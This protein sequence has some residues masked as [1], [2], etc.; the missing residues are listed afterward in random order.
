[1]IFQRGKEPKC[2]T[3]CGMH[4]AVL[5]GCPAMPAIVEGQHQCGAE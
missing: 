5:A 4:L 1:M 3:T 2:G